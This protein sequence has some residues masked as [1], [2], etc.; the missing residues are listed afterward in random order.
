MGK[1]KHMVAL[2][3]LP[4]F[5][6]ASLVSCG[7]AKVNTAKNVMQQASFYT[8]LAQQLIT[9]AESNFQNNAKVQSALVATKQALSVVVAALKAVG[10]GLDKDMTEL[11]KAVVALTLEVFA[12]VNAIQ[13]AK[14]SSHTS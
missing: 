13:Q 11:S 4:T 2:F 7:P 12:L 14:S 10:S 1:I 3:L 5:V 8:Q 9:V 6:F